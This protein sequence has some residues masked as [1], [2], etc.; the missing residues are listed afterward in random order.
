[1]RAY[2]EKN[3]TYRD[4]VLSRLRGLPELLDKS[5]CG[6]AEDEA[7]NTSVEVI[8]EADARLK[9]AQKNIIES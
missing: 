7:W 2:W 3:R 6:R 1:M 9:S 5:D 8:I 4:F